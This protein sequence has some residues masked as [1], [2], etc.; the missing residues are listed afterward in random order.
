ME[1]MKVILV[2][3]AS[4]GM[5]KDAALKMRAKGHTV[6]GAARRVEKMDDLVNAGGHAI[7][8]D[9]TSEAD[10]DAAVE[11]VIAEQGHID[12]LVN[13][14]GFGLYGA[15]EDVSIADAKHQFEVNL[16]GLAYLTQKVL[17]H[18]RSTNN[19]RIV[20]ISSMG[21][22]I[23]TPMGAWYHASKHALEG[24][25]DCL[26]IETK[27]F[28]ID[29]VVVEPGGIETEWSGIMA[30][31]LARHSGNGPYKPMVDKLAKA[32]GNIKSSP[33]GL[34]GDVI[35]TASLSRRPRT[36]YV[37]GAMAK[38]LLFIRTRLGDRIFD[39]LLRSML[40]G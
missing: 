4:A 13:N 14:A 37:K 20:N 24:W 11:K 29:V 27:Q 33:V 22:K 38:P 15:V 16:F 9:I 19:G 12:V 32:S 10:V 3:G 25:S 40:R 7:K 26:R 17:P 34:I 21:G 35:V 18:M 30:E 36:R 2:T 39:G 28:G 5:G 31:N 6:Y 8:M 23:Y 1:N